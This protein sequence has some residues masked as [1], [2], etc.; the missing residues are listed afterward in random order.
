MKIS[1]SGYYEFLLK[2][3]GV[4]VIYCTE[5][6]S[7]AYP[8]ASMLILNTQRFGAAAFSKNLSDK[9]FIGQ[10]NLVKRGYRQ[11]G[12]PGYGLRRQLIDENHNPK[13]ILILG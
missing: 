9:V 8:E 13:Q 4:K 12:S 10:V 2:I 7:D 3:N 5:S 1:L 11:G 6:I